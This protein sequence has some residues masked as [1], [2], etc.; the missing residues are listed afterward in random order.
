[1]EGPWSKGTEDP[2]DKVEENPGIR[3]EFG[4][5]S[6]LELRDERDTG[7]KKSGQRYH[8]EIVGKGR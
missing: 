8:E 1:M 2:R 5:K 7:C 4:G 3:K 6:D